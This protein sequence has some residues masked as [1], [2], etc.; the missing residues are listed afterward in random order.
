MY[1][2]KYIYSIYIT[3]EM[4]INNFTTNIQSHVFSSQAT[5]L[6][7]PYF[8]SDSA[9]QLILFMDTGQYCALT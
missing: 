7:R 5:I 2:Y 4:V 9:F 1:T 8:Y 6:S 3:Y